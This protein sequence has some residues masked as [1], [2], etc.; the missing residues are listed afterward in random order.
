MKQIQY[1]RLVLFLCVILPYALYHFKIDI[2]PEK[3]DYVLDPA[4]QNICLNKKDPKNLSLKES[5]SEFKKG[6]CTPIMFMNGLQQAKLR[7]EID[8]EALQQQEPDTFEACFWN[9]CKSDFWPIYRKPSKEYNIAVALDSFQPMGMLNPFGANCHKKIMQPA[10]NLKA[11][12]IKDLFLERKGVKVT[13]YGNTSQTRSNSR[14]GMEA[15]RDIMGANG[16]IEDFN[17]YRNLMDTFVYMGYTPG[18]T[19]QNMPYNTLNNWQTNEVQENLYPTLKRLYEIT[20]KKVALSG[21]SMGNIQV[22]SNQLKI[23]QEDKDKYV[24]HYLALFPVLTGSSQPVRIGLSGNF[25]E[26]LP[27][28]YG[29]DRW[30]G[31]L[32]SGTFMYGYWPYNMY[33]EHAETNWMKNITD[34]INHEKDPGNLLNHLSFWP[35][36]NQQ[37]YLNNE[38]GNNCA[39]GL[40]NS[41]AINPVATIKGRHYF[42]KDIKDMMIEKSPLDN[43]EFLYKIHQETDL[44]KKM[45]NFDNPGV[46]IVVF[47]NNYWPT[48]NQ[49][50]YN[51]DPREEFDK[52]LDNPK[53]VNPDVILTERGDGKLNSNSQLFAYIKWALDYDN[54][55]TSSARPVKFV[56]YCGINNQKAA[57][58]DD[59]NQKTIGSN[60]EKKADYDDLRNFGE[61]S[62]LKNKGSGKNFVNNEYIG[63]RC[64]CDDFDAKISN[65]VAGIGNGCDHIK[66]VKDRYFLYFYANSL[67][68][69]NLGDIT[70]KEYFETNEQIKS[71]IDNCELRYGQR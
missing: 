10:L 52:N 41:S 45:M 29:W 65:S 30:L 8:C 53:G 60:I 34:Q 58:F 50:V 5:L 49:F 13:H 6:P 31:Y 21:H 47:F 36:S 70:G 27:I 33:E 57:P 26:Q 25:E 14:C 55:S 20:G 69:N 12:S 67:L 51:K 68:N 32:N 71:F 62:F 16:H 22:Y 43:F 66:F 37:C 19:M 63:L 24:S 56:D 15:H 39:T 1:V 38:F 28:K 23:S 54:K 9:S 64:E 59:K 2:I 35:D 44:M 61:D 17:S 4:Y 46:P 40:Y 11:T 42:P 3:A 48:D 7:V 18:L